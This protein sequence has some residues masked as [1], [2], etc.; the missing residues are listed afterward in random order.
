M[1][2]PQPCELWA[3]A[4]QGLTQNDFIV[5]G[6]SNFNFTHIRHHFVSWHLKSFCIHCSWL[7]KV[8]WV[9][10]MLTH[11][12][13][14]V[15]MGRR[16]AQGHA[17]GHSASAAQSERNRHAHLRYATLILNVRG[18]HEIESN[19][20]HALRIYGSVSIVFVLLFI[21]PRKTD[22]C[23]T[24]G[25]R[26]RGGHGAG[27]KRSRW[28]VA[29]RSQERGAQPGERRRERRDN[30]AWRQ[31]GTGLIGGIILEIT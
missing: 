6:V 30:H 15:G 7:P 14:C 29:G 26:Q 25:G 24:R 5:E 28:V 11:P 9:R 13:G 21:D 23:R 10:L 1:S 8:L 27:I 20:R 4:R 12:P 22:G 19:H 16:P 3:R 18:L 31:V 2:Y 17:Q